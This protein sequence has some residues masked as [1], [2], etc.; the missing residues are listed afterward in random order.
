MGGDLPKQFLTVNGRCV[1][2]YTVE[3]FQQHPRID[4][5]CLVVH[6]EWLS[7]L[8]YIASD[9]PWSKVRHIIAGGTERYLS[10]LNAIAECIDE[11]DDTLMLF[12][13]AARPAIDA[14]TI[15]RLLDALQHH[16]AAGVAIPSTDT[17]WEAMPTR[18]ND[19]S[20]VICRIPERSRFW[21]AQTPQGFRLHT[22]RDAYQRALQDPQLSVTDDCGIVRRYMPEVPVAI[23]MGSE[24]N[25]KITYP[26]DLDLLKLH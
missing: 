13:D 2:E 12:H 1:I 22:I 23:V 24:S 19:P 25:I 11:P 4:D 14:D 5:I 7:H 18:I 26:R 16:D 8:R 15:D 10:S 3:A 6:P 21:R 17:L 9:K 20:P